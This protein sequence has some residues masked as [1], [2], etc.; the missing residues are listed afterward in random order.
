LTGPDVQRTNRRTRW[1][2]TGTY[3]VTTVLL[4]TGWWLTTGHEGRPSVL[5]RL[6]DTADTELHRKA[7]Y[8]LIGLFLA[9]L[10]SASAPRSRSS[11]RRCGRTAVTANGC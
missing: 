2:H 7:G 11:A 1:F 4:V 10:T 8:V 5:A 6:T 3:L 9:G